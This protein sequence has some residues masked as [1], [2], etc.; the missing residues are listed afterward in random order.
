MTSSLT[1]NIKV[2]G[3]GHEIRKY[4][5][6]ASKKSY[7]EKYKACGAEIWYRDGT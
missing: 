7:H 6:F 4:G 5:K 2:K 1:F 3:Q